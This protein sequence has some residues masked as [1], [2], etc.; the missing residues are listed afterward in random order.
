MRRPSAESVATIVALSLGGAA[1][2]I[3]T[4]PRLRLVIALIMV[5]WGVF[6]VARSLA[7]RAR[8]INEERRRDLMDGFVRRLGKRRR[9]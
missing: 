4:G 5:A 2:L 9:R 6:G 7:V 3:W 8:R 1:R